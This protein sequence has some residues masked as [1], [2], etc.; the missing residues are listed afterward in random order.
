MRMC[1]LIFL[2]LFNCARVSAAPPLQ[3]PLVTDWVDKDLKGVLSVVKLL[4]FE[5]QNIEQLKIQLLKSWHVEQFDLGF[6]ANYLELEKGYGYSKGYVH[7]LLYQGRVAQYEAGIESYSNEWPR[8]KNDILEKWKISNGPTVS[9]EEHGY[10]FRRAIEKTLSEYRSAVARV[11]GPL[12]K[13][14]VPAELSKA[15]ASLIDPM[16]NATLS[17]TQRDDDIDALMTANRVDLLDNV[18]RAYNPGARVISAL[19]LLEIKDQGTRLSLERRQTISK[20]LN[21]NIEIHVCVFDMCSHVTAKHALEWMTLGVPFPK[22]SSASLDRMGPSTKYQSLSQIYGAM[23][24]SYRHDS[25]S[26]TRP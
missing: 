3:E 15:Y 1:S 23:L 2:L 7:A 24:E 20:V 9:I 17:G 19:A 14:K 22:Q 11:L 26:K 25:H 6:G 5:T 18:L 13:V 4:P 12:K 8:I 10:V 16:N 21:L